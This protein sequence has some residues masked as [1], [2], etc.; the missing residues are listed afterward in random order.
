[1]KRFVVLVETTTN[2]QIVVMAE[3]AE[4]AGNIVADALLDP[5]ETEYKSPTDKGERTY[6]F[7]ESPQALTAGDEI[8]GG[9]VQDVWEERQ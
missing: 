6:H 4:V 8:S 3:N 1:M 7:S 9:T 2:V 5:H